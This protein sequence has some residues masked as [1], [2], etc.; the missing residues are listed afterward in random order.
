MQNIVNEIKDFLAE[1]GIRQSRLAKVADVD[2]ATIYRLLNGRQKKTSGEWQDRLRK[3]FSVLRHEIE[4]EKK[5]KQKQSNVL[6]SKEAREL[7]LNYIIESKCSQKDV[8]ITSGISQATIGRILR[9][10]MPKCETL[11]KIQTFLDR[12][13]SPD[14]G[15]KE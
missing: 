14:V 12:V 7:F 9:G 4:E 2:Q 8:S 15:A 3:A 10:R 13:S 5:A 6:S 1:T 11:Y